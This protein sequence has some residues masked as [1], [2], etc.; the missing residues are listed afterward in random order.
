MIQVSRELR[1]FPGAVTA[2]AIAAASTLIA[3][4]VLAAEAPTATQLPDDMVVQILEPTGG[5]ILRPVDWHY[6]ERH[7]DGQ[8]QWIL[9]KEDPGR[10]GY[11][12]GMSIQ[13]FANVSQ[14]TGMTPRQF[15]EGVAE[16][17]ASAASKVVARCP[18]VDQGLFSV[19][20]VEVIEGD[21]PEFRVTYSLFIS[22]E[23]DLAAVTVFGAPATQW[24]DVQDVRQAMLTFELIDMS[25]FE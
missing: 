16:E 11:E 3:S 5:K 12:T 1:W 19:F 23:S 21:D 24:S 17:R 4:P 25:R 6:T 10:G 18:E 14:V 8:F 20:C 7:A 13:L 22:D 2:V 9:S 15:L